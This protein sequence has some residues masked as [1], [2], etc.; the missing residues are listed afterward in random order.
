M[1]VKD[2]PASPAYLV[3]H[4]AFDKGAMDVYLRDDFAAA[5]KEAQS[6]NE[7]NDE[8]GYDEAG[9]WRAYTKLPRVRVYKVHTK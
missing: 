2:V 3:W 4:D 1:R 7:Y 6:K 8:M 5:E 9:F